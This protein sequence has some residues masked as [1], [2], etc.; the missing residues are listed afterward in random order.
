[1]DKNS[2]AAQ[3]NSHK[4]SASSATITLGSSSSPLKAGKPTG[5]RPTQ[6][7]P[8]TLLRYVLDREPHEQVAMG[9]SRER[10]MADH[11]KDWER[12]WKTASSSGK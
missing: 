4:P 6:S 5:D 1:M 11:L 3:S 2:L 9:M 8:S 10:R 12:T 7:E